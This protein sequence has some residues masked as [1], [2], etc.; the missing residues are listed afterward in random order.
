[1]PTKTFW[2][3]FLPAAWQARMH[4]QPHLVRILDNTGWLM[5]DRI[6]RMGVALVVGV[7]VARYLGPEQFGLLNYA[8]AIVTLFTAIAS[9][10][11]DN[12]VVRDLVRRPQ[13]AARTLGTCVALQL[14]GSLAAM[15]L[16]VGTVSLLRPD[17]AVA[18]MAVAVLSLGL[19]FKSTDAIR[20][21]FESHVQSK[22]TVRAEAT[23]FALFALIKVGLLVGEAPL[24]A[25]VW[26]MPAETGLAALLM[27]AAYMRQ[28]QSPRGWSFDKGRARKLLHDSAPLILSVLAVTIYT[29]IDQVMLG[30]MAGDQAVGI[31]SAAVRLSEVWY[32]VPVAIGASVFPTLIATREQ[33]MERYRHHVQRLFS[34]MSVLSLAVALPV[35]LWADEIVTLLYGT[36]FPGAADILVI[37]VWAAPFVFHGVAGSRWYLAENLQGLMFYRALAGCALNVALNLLLIP[38]YGA[39]GAAWGTVAAQAMSTF[40]FNALQAR[41][42]PLFMMQLRSLAG[43]SLLRGPHAGS[44]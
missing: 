27:A 22:Y 17:D 9:L 18:R 7:W 10:G 19:L 40:V 29:R 11:L 24:M 20:F 1:M 2:T 8:L 36:G 42:R 44:R 33:D 5:A 43:A 35:T 25:F 16:T 26:A 37:H 38:R 14:A 23:A 3:S 31:Y 13:E 41:T 12:I 6:F 15:V 28:G 21:W 4:A 34:L 39:V 30:Q 32:F